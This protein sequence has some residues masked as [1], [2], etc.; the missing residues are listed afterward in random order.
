LTA[1]DEYIV[2]ILQNVGLINREQAEE[3]LE[4]SLNQFNRVFSTDVANYRNQVSSAGI[5]LFTDIGTLDINWK[6][7]N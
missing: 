4:A 6:K 2:E 1:N 7:G 5:N 3:A